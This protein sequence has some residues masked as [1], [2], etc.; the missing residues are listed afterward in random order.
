MLD[1]KLASELV[2]ADR[3]VGL[4]GPLITPDHDSIETTNFGIQINNL[5]ELNMILWAIRTYIGGDGIITIE[6]SQI[7]DTS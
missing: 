4:H 6:K 3:I 2:T 1:F 5:P 7:A